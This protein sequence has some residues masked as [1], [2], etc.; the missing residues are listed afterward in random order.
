MQSL[1]K[2]TQYRSESLEGSTKPQRSQAER[3]DT[4]MEELYPAMMHLELGTT[5]E[6]RFQTA[7][8]KVR[9]RAK[10]S[11]DDRAE[12]EAAT[13]AEEKRKNLESTQS[14]DQ[15]EPPRDSE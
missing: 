8:K 5:G 10:R 15:G 14:C 6:A 2:L 1:E 12:W 7:L 9:A 4:L 3:L 11:V 13:A